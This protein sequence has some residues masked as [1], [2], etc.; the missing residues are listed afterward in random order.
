MNNKPKF[1]TFFLLCFP[2]EEQYIAVIM[3]AFGVL[4]QSITQFDGPVAYL[5][6]WEDFG[7]VLPFTKFV[8]IVHWCKYVN[9]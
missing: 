7:Y 3:L 9:D 1:V 6:V 2:F 5:R 8:K 4:L